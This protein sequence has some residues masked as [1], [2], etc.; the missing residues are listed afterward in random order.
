MVVPVE[1]AFT[2]DLECAG[3]RHELPDAARFGVGDPVVEDDAAG[4]VARLLPELG[5]VFLEVVGR[6]QRLVE[7][8]SL[9]QP[10]AF[11]AL[12][13]EVF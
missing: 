3:E 1:D 10:L 7:L 12:R 2:V 9:P 8:E 13:V 11:V 4:D 5:E 6:R